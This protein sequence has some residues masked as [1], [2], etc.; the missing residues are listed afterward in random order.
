MLRLRTL[1]G[2]SLEAT[3]RPLSGAAIQHRRLALLAILAAGNGQ[4]TSRDRLLGLLWPERDEERGRHA[5]AQAIYALRRALG[6][7][8]LVLGQQQLRLNPAVVDADVWEFGRAMS[9]ERHVDAATIYGGPFLDGIYLDGAPEFERWAE[10]E[11][12]RLQRA[13]AAALSTLAN[14][15]DARGALA[16]SV[17]WWQRLTAVDPL[18]AAPAMGLMRA[19]AASGDIAAALRHARHYE[20][21]L[22]AELDVPPAAEV[23]ALLRELRAH[24][25]ATKELLPASPELT[26]TGQPSTV[27]ATPSLAAP[28]SA[29]TRGHW[30]AGLTVGLSC[31]VA[32][33]I[34]A[35]GRTSADRAGAAGADPNRVA[36]FPFQT[37]G[38]TEIISLGTGA[39]DVLSAA[40]DGA[41]PLRAVDPRAL[42]ARLARDSTAIR[43]PALA[44]GISV[45]LAAGE[46]VLGAMT[47]LDGRVQVT[48]AL[49]ESATPRS[50]IAQASAVGTRDSLLQTLDQVAAK[51]LVERS[52]APAQRLAQVAAVTTSSLPALKQYLTGEAAQRAFDFGLALDAFQRAVALDS[53]FAL[54]YY[55]L[56]I[57]ADWMGRGDLAESAAARAAQYASRLSSRDRQLVEAL[58]AW[59]RRD[60][61]AAERRYRAILLHYPDDVESWYQLGEIYFHEN[62]PRGLS[63]AE[64]RA[65][66]ERELALDPGNKETMVHLMRVAAWQEQ[67][68]SVGALVR[69][70][71][72]RDE[73]PH[74]RPYRTLAEGDTV[75]LARA[76]NALLTIDAG[77]VYLSAVRFA[78]Y[79]HRLDVAAR[80]FAILTDARR[81]AGERASGY[82]A[83]GC[84][85]AARGRW[86]VARADLD[87]ARVLKPHYGL[88]AWSRLAL[89]PYAPLS[90]RELAALRDTLLRWRHVPEDTS[91]NRALF[92]FAMGEY[93]LRFTATAG[94]IAAR[95]GEVAQVA[96]AA[97]AVAT[98]GLPAPASLDAWR[99][100]RAAMLRAQALRLGGGEAAAYAATPQV[101][102]PDAEGMRDD[103]R[104]AKAE[105]AQHVGRLDEAAQLFDSFEQ[106]GVQSLPWAAPG[107]FARAELLERLER[108]REARSEYERVAE[109]WREADPEVRPMWEEAR[110]R[111]Q[112]LGTIAR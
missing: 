67:W 70:M 101:A 17:E 48:A 89:T 90:V 81:P 96:S 12:A 35:L 18:A 1:G 13:Y 7:D 91:S 25:L 63:F 16:E 5:L 28:D 38:D 69:R 78:L 2:L 32:I 83:L 30:R 54:A 34:V 93:P 79:T 39:V 23:M 98:E 84:L 99:R 41:G 108:R 58:L 74:L 77:S 46:F 37:R 56:S 52:H 10:A 95:L 4:G 24:A 62:P 21:H 15:A 87:S 97:R 102:L 105:M 14:A 11:R 53:T 20:E 86:R 57:S 44:G 71:D 45:A 50:P 36:V 88:E 82:H 55:R 3:E 107:H 61:E 51:L 94:A 68:D 9:E 80:I 72:P 31:A 8:T 66:F 47:E 111:A 103:E 106:T 60:A 110:R 59:R 6:D 75:A 49:Y 65:P 19:H 104:Y 64:A 100:E 43:S 26:S 112:R 33:G 22:R 109:L 76:I 73:D 42:L 40:L 85:A 29:R 92:E 27:A